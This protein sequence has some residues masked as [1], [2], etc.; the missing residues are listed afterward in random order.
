MTN[1]CATSLGTVTL[2]SQDGIKIRQKGD[3][4]VA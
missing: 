1:L 2:G 3:T 4:P